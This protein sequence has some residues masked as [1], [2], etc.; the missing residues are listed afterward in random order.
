M[1]ATITTRTTLPAALALL[2][3]ACQ[4][5][6]GEPTGRTDPSDPSDPSR[7][8]DPCADGAC[9]PEDAIPALG[10]AYPRLSH[11]QYENT[12][13]DLFGLSET[14]GLTTGFEDDPSGTTAFDN[15]S[16]VLQVTPN[17]W[18]DYQ[19][20]AEVMASRVIED[21]A[22]LGRL[23]DGLPADEPD[24]TQAFVERFLGQ[25]FRRP[26]TDDEVRQFVDLA[27]MAPSHYPEVPE[28]T[29]RVALVVQAALQSPHFLYRDEWG[30]PDGDGVVELTDYQLASRLAY[31]L[32]D[33]MPDAELLR[34]AEAGE[35]TRGDG[36]RA[37]AARML[38]DPK[39]EGKIR[40]FHR[41]LYDLSHYEDVEL[42]G[43]PAGI[44]RTLRAEAE[45]F[46]EDVVLENDGGV[47]ELYT[48]PYSYV[49]ADTAPLYGLDP[50]DF[51]D[52]L[53]RTELDPSQ[54]AGLFTQPGF[55]ASHDGDTAP[56]HRGIFLNLYVLCTEL[57]PP[58]VFDPPTLEGTTRR[59]RINSI[60]GPGTCGG[61]CHGEAI[62]PVGF[63]YE[64]F[65]DFGRWRT[66]DNGQPID[67]AAAF[68]FEEGT[69]G[70]DGPV[71]LAGAIADSMNAHRCYAKN[72]LEYAFGRP[73]QL[74]DSPVLQSIATQSRDEGLSVKEILIQLVD[75][76]LFRTRRVDAEEASE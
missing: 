1:R 15:D 75:S 76:T 8:V 54:R 25:A 50:A 58:P 55:I 64:T 21:A 44:G 34:A 28:A 37:Q 47:R 65:D 51:G 69:V 4:G 59:E 14:P 13:R 38:D 73:V 7:P 33:S 49:N 35:L 20:A 48:A 30:D 72:W 52:E 29:G 41:K 24:R 45:R 10:S 32:W 23:T 27:A 62:N 3:G 68:R 36:L 71:E 5:A 16:T 6:I 60:T 2:L 9:D 39:A 43:F 19:S 61:T 63:P 26:A 46:V 70:F 12:I 42:D 22:L 53:V 40:T 31:T 18:Q 74:G 17:L 57:P 66:E 67:A 56:I 11:G